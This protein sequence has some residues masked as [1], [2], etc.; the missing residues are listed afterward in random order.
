MAKKDVT[1][2][3]VVENEEVVETVEAV[4]AE[5][6]ETEAVEE[7]PEVET[8]EPETEEE[9]EEVEEE[10]VEKKPTRYPKS[11]QYEGVDPLTDGPKI[12]NPEPQN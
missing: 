10:V 11:P 7:T 3:P 12:A 4:E 8:S 2:E 5:V 9:V 6:V 1:P